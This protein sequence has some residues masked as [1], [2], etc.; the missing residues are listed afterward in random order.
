M[1]PRQFEP[2]LLNIIENCGCERISTVAAVPQCITSAS[3]E[4]RMPVHADLDTYVSNC[5]LRVD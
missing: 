1:V 5:W 4:T 3:E 2:S